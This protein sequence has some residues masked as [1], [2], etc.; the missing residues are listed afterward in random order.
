[1]TWPEDPRW[2]MTTY[3]I[4]AENGHQ[5]SGASC[6]H[7]DCRLHGMMKAGFLQNE[8]NILDSQDIPFHIDSRGQI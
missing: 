2:S 6:V 8:W 3:V 1:M 5:I 4:P 7:V